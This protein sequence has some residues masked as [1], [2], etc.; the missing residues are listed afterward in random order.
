MK[1]AWVDIFLV[2]GIFTISSSPIMSQSLWEKTNGPPGGLIT[3]IV[4]DETGN[5][6]AVAAGIIASPDYS[7]GM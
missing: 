1:R 7:I 6:M 3:G 4:V 2:F 5:N